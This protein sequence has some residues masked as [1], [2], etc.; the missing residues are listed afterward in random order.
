[1]YG[2]TASESGFTLIPLM[3]GTVIGAASTGRMM[4]HFTHYKRP[5]LIG[6]AVAVLGM[7]VIAA[8]PHGLPL[9]TFVL[10]LALAS[11]GLGTIFPLTLVSIQ[12]AVLPHQMGTATGSLNF[13]RSPSM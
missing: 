11:V 1:M 8:T 5:T 10:I 6:L 12:N 9:W 4:A 3:A 2:L 7:A 13:F